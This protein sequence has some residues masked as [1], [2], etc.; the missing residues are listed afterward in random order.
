MRKVNKKR[1]FRRILLLIVLAIVLCVG[2]IFG[3]YTMNLKPVGDGENKVDFEISEG[4]TFDQVMDS[5]EKNDLIRSATVAKVYTKLNHVN[6]YYAGDFELN[7]AMS[8]QEI[9]D[10]LGNPKNA[11]KDQVTLTVTEG[12]WAKEIAESLAK[13]FPEYKASDFEDKWNDISYI[14]KLAKDYTFLDTKTLNNKN[15]K[16][17]LEGYLFPDT[18]SFNE[19][20]TIDEITR[21][22][23]NRF[24]EV[25]DTYETEIDNSD[26]SLQ[27][28]LSLASVV[29]YESATTSDMKEIAGVFY[30]RLDDGMKLD[31][32]VT[33]CY[34]LYDQMNS[35]QDCEVE[36]DIDSPYNTYL[37]SGI[38]IG[39][40]LNPGED[41]IK[42]VLNPTKSDYYYFLAD[43]N[44]DGKVY[45]SKTLEEHEAKM[46]E[47]GLV[48]DGS[49]E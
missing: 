9:F 42:A 11:K 49:G 25:Y 3:F 41:A 28:I 10:Y 21:T 27:E 35:A 36:T 26:Y 2:I 1:R 6:T 31:S 32:S 22:F 18:Y 19:D 45:Y 39:P 23:L 37:H 46:K 5:L 47:L 13:K 8:C 14:K 17:K 40:I 29:Q 7:D 20:A 4:A 24:Q 38:P 16:I 43:I 15:Y 30:N 48:L 12:K 33:V 34:A 44:G